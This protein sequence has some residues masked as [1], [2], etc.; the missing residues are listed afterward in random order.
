MQVKGDEPR[1]LIRGQCPCVLEGHDLRRG[2]QDA[3]SHLHSEPE[4]TGLCEICRVP[5]EVPVELIA[6][7]HDMVALYSHRPCL[8]QCMATAKPIP[9]LPPVIMKDRLSIHTRIV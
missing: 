7:S 3:L 6:P 4:D 2:T 9:L 8:A 5:V 1:C